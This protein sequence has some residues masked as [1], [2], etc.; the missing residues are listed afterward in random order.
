MTEINLYKVP[1]EAMMR[2]IQAG[3]TILDL[4]NRVKK[5]NKL[6]GMSTKGRNE[7]AASIVEGNKYLDSVKVILDEVAEQETGEEGEIGG[8]TGESSLVLT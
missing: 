3:M 6:A 1:P 8:P 7:L 4:D 2:L 5:D